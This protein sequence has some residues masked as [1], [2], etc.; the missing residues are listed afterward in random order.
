MQ[1]SDRP[2]N[3]ESLDLDSQTVRIADGG[4]FLAQAGHA[5]QQ[6]TLLGHCQLVAKIGEGGMGEVFKYHHP[7]LKK[8]FAVKM[9]HSRNVSSDS[10]LRFQRE[11]MAAS[12]LNH[13]NLVSVQDFG[14]TSDLRPYMVM[15]FI[16]GMTLKDAISNRLE[17]TLSD[18]LSIIMQCCDGLQHAHEQGVLH[19]DLKPSNIMLMNL[20]RALP[21]IKILDFGIAKL[22]DLDQSA[23]ELTK[24]GEVFG[25]P[26]YM[27][28]E[29]A[30]GKKTDARTD[31]YSLGCV[32][33]DLLTGTPPFGG[34]T[35]LSIIIAHLNTPAPTLKEASL[36]KEFPRSLESC[37]AKM[38]AKEPAE[39]H[40]SMQELKRDLA[41]MQNELKTAPSAKGIETAQSQPGIK[42]SGRFG[43][44]IAAAF[45]MISAC[46]VLFYMIANYSAESNKAT[47]AEPMQSPLVSADAEL[48]VIDRLRHET[49]V[50]R[51]VTASIGASRG[52]LEIDN[53][54]LTS[55]DF[56][57]LARASNTKEIALMHCAG[58]SAKNM[59]KLKSMPIIVAS[60][61]VTDID[62]ASLDVFT[63]EHPN[64]I[65]LDLSESASLKPKDM[66][67][68]EQLRKLS[69]L[70]L[71]RM[72][73]IDQFIEQL[74]RIPNLSTLDLTDNKQITNSSMQ[75]LL[76]IPK[77][78]IIILRQ[79]GVTDVA[80]RTLIKLP[81]ASLIDLSDNS[82]ITNESVKVLSNCH[83]L[84]ELKLEN[85]SVTP[86]CV[87]YL[88]KL[89]HLHR[90]DISGQSKFTP[91][92]IN[93]MREAL[94]N[95]TVTVPD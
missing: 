22:T 36:G 40:S 9:L 48:A 10:H 56:D 94:P 93:Q 6:Q 25:S 67:A 1:N 76:R 88:K 78:G 57:S 13:Q 92:Q 91:A 35:S 87:R 65:L 16:E 28:P 49:P 83:S 46:G 70:R 41:A 14:I 68:L 8:D 62:R 45:L 61:S 30:Q 21:T 58:L 59:H 18:K 12:S 74:A 82:A 72:H 69:L 23:I 33:F 95:C 24:T 79:T 54:E 60:F 3:E 26:L 89:A 75:L 84:T 52:Y 90:L 80:A 11:A 71:K 44:I 20:D 29:Q 19:R 37:V 31:I 86:A 43:L 85:T 73:Q 34:T 2:Q 32:L 53:R 66:V 64:L 77:L 7:L 50:D 42:L 5:L 51:A 81:H 39:R 17:F 47:V 38:L 4:N 55:A 15:D 27:S 63:T